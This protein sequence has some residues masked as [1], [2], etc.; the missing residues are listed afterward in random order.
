M[1]VHL[2]D[3]AASKFEMREVDAAPRI[4]FMDDDGDRHKPWEKWVRRQ[5][6]PP[7]FKMVW[8]G[9]DAMSRLWADEPYD[10]VCLDHDMGPNAY[11]RY[12]DPSIP[13]D[14]NEVDG[15]DVANAIAAL[16]PRKRPKKAICHSFQTEKAKGMARILK[17][18]GIEVMVAQFPKAYA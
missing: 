1:T 12:H 2:S 13:K 3:E 18:A 9:E 5:P 17:A 7:D 6:G 11:A 8:G 15:T 16:P 14:V 10:L 4:L